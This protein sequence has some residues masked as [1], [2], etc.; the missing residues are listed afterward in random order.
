MK[1][2]FQIGCMAN[3][4]LIYVSVTQSMTHPG[5]ERHEEMAQQKAPRLCYSECLKRKFI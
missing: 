5:T 3:K 2:L 1:E 4:W